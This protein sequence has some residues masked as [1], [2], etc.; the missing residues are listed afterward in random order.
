MAESY[1]PGFE[2]DIEPEVD[3]LAYRS[4]FDLEPEEREPGFK[5]SYE[6]FD[7]FTD[8]EF[9]LDEKYDNPLLTG[10]INTISGLTLGLSDHAIIGLGLM[11]E[12]D[13]REYRGR[14][15]NAAIVGD[16]LGIGGSVLLPGG[17]LGKAGKALL[18]GAAVGQKVLALE[19]QVAKQLLKYGIKKKAANKLSKNIIG[20][21]SG[22]KL[23]AQVGGAAAGGAAEG[24][25]FGVTKTNRQW[26]ADEIEST[27][28]GIMEALLTNVS[29]ESIYGGLFGGAIPFAG[30]LAKPVYGAGKGIIKK[31][32]SKLQDFAEKGKKGAKAAEGTFNDVAEKTKLPIEVQDSMATSMKT[33]YTEAYNNS[34]FKIKYDKDGFPIKKDGSVVKEALENPS[35]DTRR[36]NIR[37]DGK[38]LVKQINSVSKELGPQDVITKYTTREG[39]DKVFT[40]VIDQLEEAGNQGGRIEKLK[41]WWSGVTD[42]DHVNFKTGEGKVK[43]PNKLILTKKELQK[44]MTI[45]QHNDAT[46]SYLE[47]YSPD[48]A[49]PHTKDG[50]T[51]NDIKRDLYEVFRDAPTN[52]ARAI[53]GEDGAERVKDIIQ[54]GN[55]NRI[56]EDQLPKLKEFDVEKVTEQVT[57]EATEFAIDAGVGLVSS[58]IPGGQYLALGRGVQ[59]LAKADMVRRLVLKAGVLDGVEKG[60]DIVFDSIEGFVKPRS[61]FRAPIVGNM[62]KEITGESDEMKQYKAMEKI[63]DELLTDPTKLMDN[64]ENTNTLLGTVEPEVAHAFSQMSG[65]VFGFLYEKFP[66]NPWKDNYLMK[67]E[68][69][70]NGTDMDDFKQYANYALKP[71]N[72]YKDLEAGIVTPQG[73]EVAQRFTPILHGQVT[74]EIADRIANG[75]LELDYH[76]RGRMTT[77]TGIPFD[78]SL[79]Y[80]NV[81][82]LQQSFVA[83]EHPGP[84]TNATGLGKIKADGR[85]KTSTQNVEELA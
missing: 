52:A 29:Q 83:E 79:E 37:N 55:A 13:M 66:K 28:Q 63:F 12:T 57:N 20:K 32:A 74:Y 6:V 1:L 43:D 54:Q 72:I 75:D 53:D 11:S 24:A 68:W 51:D 3:P 48:W 22:N 58:V 34:K 31:G 60:V 47:T 80:K 59:R 73:A 26:A 46:R 62:L 45:T 36:A 8:N 10:T 5:E 25:A 35:A 50:L 69:V 65:E 71:I 19:S 15:E 7:R 41:R 14:N 56:L 27:P 81:M 64:V 4:E 39:I 78:S 49:T 84:Q 67:H 9:E 23:R 40:N 61:V 38:Q 21:M 18:P 85:E 33:K 30:L 2:P 42:G 76:G 44:P 82:G 16:V 77:W 70:P 17:F